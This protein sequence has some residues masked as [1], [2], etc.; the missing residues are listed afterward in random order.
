M[1]NG[2]LCLAAIPFDAADYKFASTSIRRGKVFAL[3]NP[4]C[5]GETL[6]VIA[7]A[8]EQFGSQRV[9]R[10]AVSWWH[11]YVIQHLDRVAETPCGDE[12]ANRLERFHGEEPLK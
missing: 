11:P 12:F 10:F 1:R 7:N 9:R 6:A 3:Q 8:L 4:L 2:L 5:E